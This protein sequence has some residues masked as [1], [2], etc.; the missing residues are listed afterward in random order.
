MFVQ[1]HPVYKEYLSFLNSFVGGKKMLQ[2]TPTIINENDITAKELLPILGHSKI[3]DFLDR[4]FNAK[5]SSPEVTRKGPKAIKS[6]F[7]FLLKKK[8]SKGMFFKRS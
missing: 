8:S 6:L 1:Y 7:E 5:Y 4:P 2:I 3:N